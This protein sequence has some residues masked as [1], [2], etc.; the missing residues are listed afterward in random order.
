MIPVKYIGVRPTYRDGTYGSYIEFTQGQTV[1]IEDEDLA[2]KLLRHKDVYVLGE[3]EAATATE[4]KKD[5]SKDDEEENQS[6]DTRDSIASMNKNSLATF[7]KTNFNVALDK[8]QSVGALR[9]EVVSLFD[10]FGVA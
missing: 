10:R 5:K 7:A 3:A 2:R 1:N 6:Q 9:S 4:P 8:R